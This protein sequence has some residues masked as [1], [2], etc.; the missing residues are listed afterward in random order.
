[1][2]QAVRVGRQILLQKEGKILSGALVMP[3]KEG[4]IEGNPL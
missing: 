2:R 4:M 1:M 3:S